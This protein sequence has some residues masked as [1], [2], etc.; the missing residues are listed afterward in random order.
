MLAGIGA[1]VIAIVI[2]VRTARV[3]A[4]LRRLREQL[5]SAREEERRRLRRDLHDGIGPQLAS[6]MLTL[7]AACKLLRQD[8]DAAEKL[9]ADAITHAQQA[10]TDIRRLVYN[11]R[12]PALDDLGLVGALREQMNQYHGSTI[13][14]AI[15][16]PEPLPPLSAAVE[17]A[18][19]RIAQE[20]LTNVVRH[21]HACTCVIRLVLAET[22]L[23]E[24]SDDGLGLPKG[25]QA[26]VGLTS[27][28]ERAAELGGTCEIGPAPTRGTRV[29]VRLPLSK[30]Q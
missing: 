10:V 25:R 21:A 20:A 16:A 26:G 15:E 18:C 11:L 14:F 30:G 13:T 9:L 19:Y 23:L 3:N 12:P 17:V 4:N 8:P 1:V 29:T 22:L 24:V 7:T 6:Q 28:R 27:M 2:A 5:I